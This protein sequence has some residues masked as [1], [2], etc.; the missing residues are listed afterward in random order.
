MSRP[1]FSGLFRSPACMPNV[2]SGGLADGSGEQL[3]QRLGRDF[4]QPAEPQNRG[5]PLA[6]VDESVGGRAP[7]TEQRGSLAKVEHRGQRD[8]GVQCGWGARRAR[9]RRPRRRLV[10]S[11]L[12]LG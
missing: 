5:R 3:Q 10:P 11:D 1:G 4:D 6:V 8:R 2:P 7:H 12:L 9:T